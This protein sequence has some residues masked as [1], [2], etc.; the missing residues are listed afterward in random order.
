MTASGTRAR[1]GT[2]AADTTRYP[3]GT[4]M[5][6]DGY[7]MGRVEDQGG[8][9]TGDHVDLFFPSHREA[10]AWGKRYRWVDIWYR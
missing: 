5:H 2:L 7:G 6:I 1:R 10:L 4:V 9:I 8:G 3:F